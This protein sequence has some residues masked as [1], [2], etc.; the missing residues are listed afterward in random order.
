[1]PCCHQWTHAPIATPMG[2]RCHTHSGWGL[3]LCAGRGLQVY[4][5]WCG[6]WRQ[7]R[8]W[9]KLCLFLLG[10]FA[11]TSSRTWPGSLALDPHRSCSAPSLLSLVTPAQV[12]RGL[13]WSRS[14][15]REPL[16]LLKPKT[17]TSEPVPGLTAGAVKLSLFVLYW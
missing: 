7:S 13:S 16:L 17:E 14:R 5:C 10:H 2:R 11:V 8:H 1:M 12:C 6:W 15:A 4:N 9:V 3:G